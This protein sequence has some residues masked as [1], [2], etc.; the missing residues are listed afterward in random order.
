MYTHVSKCK[1]D[2]R[3]KGKKYKEIRE[4][5]KRTFLWDK[6]VRKRGFHENKTSLLK[7]PKTNKIILEFS[8]LHLKSKTRCYSGSSDRAPA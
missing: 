3:G 1:N 7:C 8:N 5:D 6:Q 2:K 4:K